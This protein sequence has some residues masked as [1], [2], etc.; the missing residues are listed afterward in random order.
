MT[1]DPDFLT[2]TPTPAL[3]DVVESFWMLTNRSADDKPVIILPD[4]RIDLS[5]SSRQPTHFSL[6]GLES[7]PGKGLIRGHECMMAVS[8]R[9]LAIEYM[10]GK[11]T[12]LLTNTFYQI[13]LADFDFRTDSI[14]G[15]DMFVERFTEQLV[16]RF[17]KDCR[18][19][20]AIIGG[21]P[22]GLTLARLLQQKGIS[23]S[24]YE[25]APTRKVPDR[26]FPGYLNSYY[27]L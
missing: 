15:F 24:V 20:I 5:F 23:V 17:Y 1:Q 16:R 8:F 19:H 25:R 26:R 21:G 11:H 18:L 7:Q 2:R 12:T 27:G 22:G 3:A 14:S 13:P 10:F 4:G 9:P 6:L